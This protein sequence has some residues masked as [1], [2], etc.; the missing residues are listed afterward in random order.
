MNADRRSFFEVF[1]AEAETRKL[2]L[3]P[4]MQKHVEAGFAPPPPYAKAE[5][6]G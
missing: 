1:Y 3:S 6:P 2:K 5:M 4:K